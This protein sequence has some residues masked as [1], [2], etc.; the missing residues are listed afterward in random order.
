MWL[1]FSSFVCQIELDLSIGLWSFCFSWGRKIRNETRTRKNRMLFASFV[2]TLS[3]SIYHHSVYILFFIL[4]QTP[5]WDERLGGCE[6]IYHPSHVLGDLSSVR[7][8]GWDRVGALL[9]TSPGTQ[10]RRPH[11]LGSNHPRAGPGQDQPVDKLN[12]LHW[13]KDVILYRIYTFNFLFFDI[14]FFFL[15]I[16]ALSI[17]SSEDI[18]K[19]S[20][21]ISKWMVI[22][23]RE[24]SLELLIDHKWVIGIYRKILLVN[25]V[26]LFC[27][28]VLISVFLLTLSKQF[29]IKDRPHFSD[30]KWAEFAKNKPY[31]YGNKNHDIDRSSSHQ[32]QPFGIKMGIRYQEST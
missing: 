28:L 11:K 10:F 23:Y 3:S 1:L 6:L 8:R 17:I 26:V 18:L 7:I 32:N 9:K 21:Q 30:A 24:H 14:C 15:I 5:H 13:Y 16:S 4:S 2:L 20:V 22:R 12:L 27:A 25:Q 29:C 19:L 31:L